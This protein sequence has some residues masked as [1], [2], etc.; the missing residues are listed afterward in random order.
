[1]KHSKSVALAVVALL[2]CSTAASAQG[3]I[4]AIAK[5]SPEQRAKVQTGLMKEKLALTA[6]QLPKVEAI[7]LATAQKMQPVLESTDG[8]MIR[9]RK[10]RANEAERDT[11]LEPVLTPQQYQQ[12]LAAKG[13]I[14][15]KAEQKLLEKRKSGGN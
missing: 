2:S 15:Q 5:T 14:K 6:E 7:N 9:M 13:E 3:Q 11:A 10:A 1:M 4:E 8:P 12:W